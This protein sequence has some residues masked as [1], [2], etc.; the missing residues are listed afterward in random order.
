MELD[1][2]TKAIE[3][4]HENWE[5]SSGDA[6]RTMT[7]EY[8]GQLRLIPVLNLSPSVVLL[9][10]DNYR[11]AA[12]LEDLPGRDKVMLNPLAQDSQD[13]LAKLLSSTDDF[14]N[15]KIQLSELGQK[16]PGLI[17]ADG[18]L[19]NGNT[20][21][22]ALRELGSANV[23]V[24]LLPGSVTSEDVLNLQVQLQMMRLV[25]QD[26]TFTNELLLIQKLRSANGVDDD[27]IARQLGWKPG[28]A[29]RKKLDQKKRLLGIIKE[30]RNLPES[31]VLPYSHFD[32][33]EEMLQ[34]LD[35][36]YEAKKQSDFHN[37]EKL[38]WSRI[39][40]MAFGLTKDQVRSI[41]EDF[42]DD[43]VANQI[44][45]NSILDLDPPAASSTLFGP[46]ASSG[47][48]PDQIKRIAK[49]IY[50]DKETS[51]GGSSSANPEF[52][53]LGQGF[54]VGA[55]NKI[56]A[57]RLSTMLQDPIKQLR[58]ARI[59]FGDFG[60]QLS[61]L[62]SETSFDIEAFKLELQK[63][64]DELDKINQKITVTWE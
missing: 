21:A 48:Q 42:L 58:D 3:V 33:R 47:R 55:E 23:M 2:R 31:A 29:S 25:H 12:Q 46:G 57:E 43:H 36:A 5:A 1:A 30:I 28:P 24:G 18:L 63:V 13:L 39:V 52:A 16:E 34:D 53:E 14:K 62:M 10:H 4:A 59:K 22:V 56:N 49:A 7:V 15:L 19:V 11:L 41:N 50:D 6:R 26:Y 8:Q 9:N 20:R 60:S 32:S 45:G 61:Q 17:T 38:K 51:A 35:K 64:Q 37:A 54:K 44:P 40:G 27:A